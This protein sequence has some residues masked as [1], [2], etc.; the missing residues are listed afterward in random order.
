MDGWMELMKSYF[1]INSTLIKKFTV[2]NKDYSG[3]P[4]T[5][6]WITLYLC[7][8]LCSIRPLLDIDKVP[9]MLLR[10]FLQEIYAYLKGHVNCV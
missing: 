7:N 1:H 9:R 10:T 6:K 3:A 2:L 4:D 8:R 5:K